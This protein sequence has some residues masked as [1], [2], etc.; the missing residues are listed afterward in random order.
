MNE[1]KQQKPDYCDE[2]ANDLYKPKKGNT[3]KPTK[4]DRYDEVFEGFH[5]L[6][7]EQSNPD[8]EPFPELEPLPEVLPL[9]DVVPLPE[10]EPL[11]KVK[12]IRLKGESGRKRQRKE[13]GD[14]AK[15]QDSE[16]SQADERR[17]SESLK[18]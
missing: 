2:L 3:A 5:D 10:L 9:P 12:T 13:Q 4:P 16:A 17:Q 14:E 7:T 15:R 18:M 6:I 11:P 1:T 8:V